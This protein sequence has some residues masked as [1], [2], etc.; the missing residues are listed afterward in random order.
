MTSFFQVPPS[1]GVEHS[2]D[3]LQVKTDV[4]RRFELQT[5][6]LLRVGARPSQEMAPDL[7]MQYGNPDELMVSR[8]PRTLEHSLHSQIP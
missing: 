4:L 3:L 8:M 7:E 1:V 2:P 6:M 5:K